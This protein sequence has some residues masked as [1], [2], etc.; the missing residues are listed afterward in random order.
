MENNMLNENSEQDFQIKVVID[1]YLS[2]GNGLFRAI[3]SFLQ[4]IY[5]R[6]TIPQYRASTTI[7]VKMKKKRVS[8]S[9]LA[10]F[11]DMGNWWWKRID[12]EVEILKS[13]T[14]IQNTV[15]KMNLNIAFVAE[16]E[17]AGYQ[18]I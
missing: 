18:F 6:Y 14:L 17:M 13:R 11:A 10:A 9:E 12:S 4:P 8:L 2:A 1:Q 7:L 16:G 5:L 15:R 3:V